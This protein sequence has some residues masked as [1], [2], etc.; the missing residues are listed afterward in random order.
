MKRLF[1]YILV[2]AYVA[3]NI[4]GCG[5][6]DASI[7]LLSTNMKLQLAANEPK[8]LQMVIVGDPTESMMTVQEDLK[9][10][11]PALTRELVKT[12]FNFEIFCATTSY[13][14]GEITTLKDSNYRSGADFDFLRLSED[15]GKCI[16][17]SL[18]QNLEGDER[19]L[20]AAKK[21]WER[22]IS[23]KAL[24]PTAVKLTMIVTNEDDCSRDLAKYPI[25]AEGAKCKDQSARAGVDKLLDIGNNGYEHIYPTS[26]YAE[27]FDKYLTY[28]DKDS[29]TDVVRKRGHIFA[30]MI[31][32][33]P[34]DIG[35]SA[36]QACIGKRRDAVINP[37]PLPA[38]VMSYGYR[39]FE[40]AQS[41]NNKTYSLC[42]NIENTLADVNT[43]VQNEVAKKSFFLQRRPENPNDLRIKITRKITDESK[44]SRILGEMEKENNSSPATNHWKKI[45][46]T[47]WEK[48]MTVGNG[49]VYLPETNEIIFNNNSYEPYNDVL[50]ILSYQPAGFDAK[51][52]Y[53]SNEHLKQ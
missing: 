10:N 14:G 53:G 33:P 43:T 32:Q 48:V 1:I 13:N 37:D 50:T 46:K 17:T 22:V 30:P 16:N 29:K 7:S 3:L 52:N 41:T 34:A 31:L 21:T 45:S 8:K 47:I 12:N 26:R 39:Y 28:E 6:D 5:D 51:V 18:D 36:A 19:G 40:V 42:E 15:I 11:F 4:V 23:T 25:N 20:E 9:N 44:A 49:F 24:D 27:F 2:G 38:F 35:K